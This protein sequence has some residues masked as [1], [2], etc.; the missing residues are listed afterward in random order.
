MRKYALMFAILSGCVMA[1]PAAAQTADEPAMVATIFHQPSARVPGLPVLEPVWQP[2]SH[3]TGTLLVD[4]ER[5]YWMAQADGVRRIVTGDDVLGDAGLGFGDAVHMSSEEERC[6][7]A[8]DF[9]P[10]YPEII[11]WWPVY[12]PGDD[13]TLYVLN[14]ASLER[15]ITSPEA[16]RSWGFDPMW[17][18]W[19]DAGDEQWLMFEDVDPPFPFRDG[20]LVQTEL[21][22]YLIAHGRSFAFIPA[23]L[24]MEAGYGEVQRLHLTEAR[25]R[26]LAPASFALERSNFDVCPTDE[27]P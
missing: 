13:E 23:S 24:V 3:P 9:N 20:T 2:R 17:F 12:G 1:A 19:F 14:N 18:D 15:R 5:V 8:D 7:P 11:D 4:H 6:L 21:A 27:M 25:L 16:M 26:E 22:T 10:W